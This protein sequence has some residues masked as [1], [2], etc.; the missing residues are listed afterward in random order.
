MKKIFFIVSIICLLPFASY[1]G[2]KNNISFDKFTIPHEV[3]QQTCLPQDVSVFFSDITYEMP[4]M[5]RSCNILSANE[6][7]DP[8]EGY[9]R[10]MFE[11]NSFIIGNILRPLG[12]IYGYVIP[13][14]G[15]KG[16]SR[17]Y[18]NIEV[19]GRLINCLL[20]ARFK[21]SGIELSR[22]LVNTTAGAAG[23][24]DVAYPWLEMAPQSNSFGQTFAYWGMKP[25]CYF[26]IPIQGGTTLRDGIGLIGDWLAD[27]I[28]WIPPWNIIGINYLSLGIKTGLSF[29]EMTLV[30]DD[31]VK[32]YN[33]SAD[34]Y[35]TLK[36]VSTAITRLKQEDQKTD[37]YKTIISVDTD[38]K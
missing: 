4:F 18:N 20:Q 23:F 1:S 15:R 12:R 3:K 36:S 7:I 26:V 27:P 2:I 10:S 29:N 32:I 30:I 35:F 33:A 8:L 19:P 24:Y 16:I 38:K 5:E 37:G 11:A 9:N 6:I 31:Y 25:G 14:Y 28:T 22:F 21:R 13:E 17:M 34:P